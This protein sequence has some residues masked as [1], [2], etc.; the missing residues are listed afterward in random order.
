[1]SEIRPF[2]ARLYDLDKVRLGDVVAPPYDV[3]SPQ[4]QGELYG[5]SENNIVRLILNR[6]SDPYASAAQT[7]KRWNA[8]GIL[9]KDDVPAFYIVSQR[10]RLPDGTN[11]ERIGFIAACRIEE[12]GAGSIFPHEKTHSGPKEDRFRLFV[13]IEM[14]NS[15]ILA[16]YSDAEQT[17]QPILDNA[18]SREPIGAAMFD[19]VEN[20]LWR[21]SDSKSIGQVQAHLSRKKI[22]IADG[23]HRYETALAYRNHLR[24][25]SGRS[26]GNEPYEFVPIYFTNMNAEG[27]TVLPT[28]RLLHSVAGFDAKATLEKL[29][30]QFVVEPVSDQ[31]G[32][33]EAMKREHRCFG[34]AIGNPVTLYLVKP[35]AGIQSTLERESVV[36]KLD[37]SILHTRILRDTLGITEEQQDKKLN[38]DYEKEE[39]AAIEAVRTGKAQAAFLMNPTPV[40]D[41]REVAEAGFVMPQKSTY[42]Y[43]KLLSG[44]VNYSFT[45]E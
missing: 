8:D 37:V 33:A 43:P 39:G 23:H 13:S 32:L 7:L 28:H 18:M 26:G 11:R 27:L 44:L 36:G 1:M 45:E 12:F 20:K 41:V 3:I 21:L 31:A 22:F 9:R 6:D 2:K 24:K 10:F 14:M 15:Q 16:I 35:G 25:E 17:L 19:G 4:L 34:L 30:K 40:E 5:K 42:F 38:V 29:R